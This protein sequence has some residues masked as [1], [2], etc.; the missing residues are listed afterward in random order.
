MWKLIDRADPDG[1]PGWF[2]SREA[3]AAFRREFAITTTHDIVEEVEA[4]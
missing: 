2:E 3:A 4:A 1:E